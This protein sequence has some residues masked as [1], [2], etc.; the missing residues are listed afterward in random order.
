MRKFAVALMA[1]LLAFNAPAMAQTWPPQQDGP[2]PSLCDQQ[3]VYLCVGLW[4]AAIGLTV[5]LIDKKNKDKDKQIAQ[6]A[7]L[8]P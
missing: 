6:A 2:P 4:A 8:S 3:G 7:P 5:Y 1:G